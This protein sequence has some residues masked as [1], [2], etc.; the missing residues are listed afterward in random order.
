MRE[1]DVPEDA[2]PGT[3]WMDV[4]IGRACASLSG[5]TEYWYRKVPLS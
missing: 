5:V 4:S 1:I 2:S 3:H